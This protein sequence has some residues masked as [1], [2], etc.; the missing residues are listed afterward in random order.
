MPLAV[1]VV[2]PDWGSAA[3]INRT[4][5]VGKVSSSARWVVCGILAVLG[6]LALVVA[7]IYLT[8][9]IHSIPSF[10]PGKHPVNGHY[11]KRGAVAA[12]IGIVLL[13]IA[14]VIGLRSRRP[15]TTP[16][17]STADSGA[18]PTPGTSTLEESKDVGDA[19]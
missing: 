7:V 8:V 4:K 17:G 18:I 13:A 1:G 15:L 10:I 16:V 9:P 6:V 5:E 19:V 2:G 12:V 3:H 11:H 14:A